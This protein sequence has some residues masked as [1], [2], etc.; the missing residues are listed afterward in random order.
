MLSRILLLATGMALAA[1]P[2]SPQDSSPRAK[3]L[4]TRVQDGGTLRLATGVWTPSYTPT[5]REV[6]YN[7]DAQ[8]PFFLALDPGQE[9][10]D[11][12]ALPSSEVES[13]TGGASASKVVNGFE[14]AYATR[15]IRGA[16]SYTLTFYDGQ[17]P[18][19]DIDEYSNEV[20]RIVLD[21]LP[22]AERARNAGRLARD[23]RSA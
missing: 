7:N 20:A 8:Q 10:A 17:V 16:F 11:F 23:D 2:A 18:C 4:K 6:I 21:N 1:L 13:L 19:T 22:G 3:R 5:G 12:G 15:E 9:F 14:F